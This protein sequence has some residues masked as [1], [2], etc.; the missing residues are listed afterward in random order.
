MNKCVCCHGN[1][2]LSPWKWDYSDLWMS[3]HVTGPVLVQTGDVVFT[4]WCQKIR[5]LVFAELKVG[6][7]AAVMVQHELKTNRLCTVRAGEKNTNRLTCFLR[8]CFI[9][10]LFL[11]MAHT[12]THK[13]KGGHTH[14]AAAWWSQ[15][16]EGLTSL[17]ILLL[18][19]Q[20]LGPKNN[21][22]VFYCVYSN[23]Q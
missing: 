4:F 19:H 1:G 6:D 3:L 23:I 16:A 18:F 15:R 11:F 21:L 10:H 2:H 5:N 7:A 8:K 17:L 12:H 20:L 13:H 22:S 14:A 9:I